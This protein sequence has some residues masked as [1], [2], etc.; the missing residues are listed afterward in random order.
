MIS[1]A[2]KM[3]ELEALTWTD[4]EFLQCNSLRYGCRSIAPKSK[5]GGTAVPVKNRWCDSGHAA[6]KHCFCSLDTELL[7]VSFRIQYLPREF[8]SVT[9]EAIYNLPSAVQTLNSAVARLQR[10]QPSVFLAPT[11]DLNHF[12]FIAS[13]H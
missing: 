8:T 1:L 5:H 3:N 11:S 2:I 4:L 13:F 12:S 9:V 6:M 7:A 10:Q